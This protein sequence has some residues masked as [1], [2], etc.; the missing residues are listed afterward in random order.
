M[1]RK[2]RKDI[3][4]TN[5]NIL[6]QMT[7]SQ[8][9]TQSSLLVPADHSIPRLELDGMVSEMRSHDEDP[10]VDTDTKDSQEQVV[11][12]VDKVVFKEKQQKNK[13]EL[14]SIKI[15][16]V[17]N[18]SL[19]EKK[20]MNLTNA[21]FVEIDQLYNNA[22]LYDDEHDIDTTTTIR[23]G[24][25]NVV[26]S[27]SLD[28]LQNIKQVQ[29]RRER[30]LLKHDQRY[31]FRQLED[32]QIQSPTSS[33]TIESTF[34]LTNG[35]HRNKSHPQEEDENNSGGFAR[36]ILWVLV[37]GVIGYGG[38][39]IYNW[40]VTKKENERQAYRMAQADRVLGDMQMVPT[41]DHDDNELL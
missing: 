21:T 12:R 1:L 15:H 25:R 10:T 38:Y 26:S 3:A 35:R 27:T 6:L 17:R 20:E 7:S 19:M 29:K 2:K 23:N 41:S 13:L 34:N 37:L 14:D 36:F 8:Q 11:D 30:L 16:K 22:M 32:P 33:P 9:R 5:F 31:L 18:I 39:R 4:T 24:T 28:L 40:Y